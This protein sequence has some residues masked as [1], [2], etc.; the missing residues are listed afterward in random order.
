MRTQRKLYKIGAWAFVLVGTG[1][2]LTNWLAPKTIELVAMLNSMREF[3]IVMPGS[4]GN[5]YQYHTGFSLMMG[6][7]LIA[8]GMQMLLTLT[9]H[10]LQN[11]RVLTFHTLVATIGVVLSVMYFF[12]VP[13]AFMALAMITF[14]FCLLLAHRSKTTSM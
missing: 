12:L 5:L 6:C 14:S 13:I 2:L 10:I 11:I 4:A 9:D 3:P 8:Y 7:L 1:H